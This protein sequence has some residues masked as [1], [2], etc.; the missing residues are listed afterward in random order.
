VSN[1]E[2]ENPISGHV[3]YEFDLSTSNPEWSIEMDQ[4]GDG[5]H[6]LL[7]VKVNEDNAV[8]KF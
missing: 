5:D 2:E 3:K 1:D 7:I 8:F 6:L 4:R